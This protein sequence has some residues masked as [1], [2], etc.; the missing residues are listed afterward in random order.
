LQGGV[1]MCATARDVERLAT[2]ML[3][4][5]LVT[6]QTGAE[7]KLVST[8][9]VSERVPVL[10]EM[11]LAVMFDR[12]AGGPVIIASPAGGVNIEEVA[13]RTPQLIFKEI[14]D[15]LAGPTPAQVARLAAGLMGGAHESA[16]VEALLR[17]EIALYWRLFDQTDATMLEI[18]PLAEVAGERILA[19]DAKVNFD[20]NAAFRQKP[21]HALRDSSQED[22]REVRAAQF[23]LNYI[24]LDGNIGCL[25]NGAGLAMATMDIIKYSG[26]APANFLDVGGGAT[27]DQVREAIKIL[28]DDPHVQAILVNIFGGIMRCDTISDGLVAAANEVGLTKPLVVRLEG[29][30]VDEGLRILAHAKLGVEVRTAS[31]LDEAAK[32]AV[33]AAA[34]N[35]AKHQHKKKPAAAATAA[36]TKKH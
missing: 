33:A 35:V 20:D 9:L 23:D 36:A 12:T 16:V 31:K 27:R 14:V 2:Q 17:D 3:G 26:G 11:Y 6:K 25:V 22:A 19:L 29:T 15:P 32:L 4:H 28:N 34:A 1:H 5:T 21:I 7:G 18:N 8:V 10:R 30:N 24:G 13:A